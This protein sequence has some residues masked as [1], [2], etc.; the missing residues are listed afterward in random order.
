MV[1]ATQ[2]NC[3]P[4]Q[5]RWCGPVKVPVIS[6]SCSYGRNIQGRRGFPKDPEA[7]SFWYSSPRCKMLS[8]MTPCHALCMETCQNSETKVKV[9][10][11]KVGLPVFDLFGWEDLI[12]DIYRFIMAETTIRP[13]RL[14]VMQ[15]EL[16][17]CI[18]VELLSWR[19]NAVMR[20]REIFSSQFLRQ[21]KNK[22]EL[23]IG[24]APSARPDCFSS[25]CPQTF[26][27]IHFWWYLLY[28]WHIYTRVWLMD[29]FVGLWSLTVINV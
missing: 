10:C 26:S 15:G 13:A 11:R 19:W 29:C 8:F 17:T 7:D 1:E 5:L 18:W 25:R 14:A 2:P 21:F 3:H 23:L 6:C 12:S 20:R 28:N 22:L 9:A 16:F 24:S 4:R 27:T